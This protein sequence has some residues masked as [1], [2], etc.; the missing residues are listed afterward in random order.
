[1]YWFYDINF[2]IQNDCF[3]LFLQDLKCPRCNSDFIEE[4]GL[5]LLHMAEQ[6]TEMA[7]SNRGEVSSFVCWQAIY[8]IV[9]TFVF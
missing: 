6:D 1:M 3:I 8:I 5:H 2:C 4:M 7:T 9:A